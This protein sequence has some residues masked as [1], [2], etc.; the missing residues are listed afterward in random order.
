MRVKRCSF[1]KIKK[2]VFPSSKKENI[3]TIRM[4]LIHSFTQVPFQICVGLW[5]HKIIT[6]RER[7]LS[8]FT[9]VKVLKL[10]NL[11]LFFRPEKGTFSG[12]W[13]PKYLSGPLGHHRSWGGLW[14]LKMFFFLTEKERQ[15]V[16]FRHLDHCK[17]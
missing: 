17:H 7:V 1:L 11:C 10:N 2:T 9:M 5:P 4:A 13:S 6:R 12:L 3:D 15:V 8:M 14:P 16:E